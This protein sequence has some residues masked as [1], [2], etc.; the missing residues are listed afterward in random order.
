MCWRTGA[1]SERSTELVCMGGAVGGQ[2]CAQV[3]CGVA[4]VFT[5]TS[6]RPV[7]CEAPRTT[8]ES[9]GS[10]LNGS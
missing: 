1:Y 8:L 6:P 2:P 7:L 3:A 10:P 9:E 4:L 5:L